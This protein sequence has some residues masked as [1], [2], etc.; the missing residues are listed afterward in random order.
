[1]APEKES[2]GD[3]TPPPLNPERGSRGRGAQCARLELLKVPPAL[4]GARCRFQA[5]AETRVFEFGR[6]VGSMQRR[7]CTEQRP[8]INI[9][10]NCMVVDG[11]EGEGG[12]GGGGEG[13]GEQSPRIDKALKEGRL[14]RTPTKKS[15]RFKKCLCRVHMS[16]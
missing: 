10:A 5:A 7:F 15:L 11:G 16:T 1:V 9:S 8:F 13:E 4:N 14:E 2:H 3:S 6:L 12:G